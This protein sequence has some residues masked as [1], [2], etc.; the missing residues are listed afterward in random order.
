[1][2]DNEGT[3]LKSVFRYYKTYIPFMFIVLAALFGVYPDPAALLC[4][5]LDDHELGYYQPYF[6]HFVLEAVRRCGLCDRYT[7]PILE[8]WKEPIRT[9]PKG[10]PEGFYPQSDY[11][12]D[13]SHGWG[14]TPLYT[15]P[16]ALSGLEILEPGMSRIRLRP[17]LLGL[18]SA[19]VEIPFPAGMLRIEMKQGKD[20]VLTLPDGVTVEE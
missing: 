5:T 17:T 15:L 14:G 11:P 3:F 1:L 4:R 19:T 12:F 7:R 20:P 10:L 8:D 18:D 2:K 6:A 9:C 16:M 13:H